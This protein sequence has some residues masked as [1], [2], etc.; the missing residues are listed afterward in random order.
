[1][2]VGVE[3]Y[4]NPPEAGPRY[5]D[6]RLAG[7]QRGPCFVWPQRV[8]QCPRGAL[9]G[10]YWQLAM[11]TLAGPTQTSSHSPVVKSAKSIAPMCF[12][13]VPPRDASAV[14]ESKPATR[15]SL[16]A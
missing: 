7:P 2:A 6:S 1:M 9:R 12:V 14:T 11:I 4:K 5:G 10:G 3:Q 15:W 16:A 13:S 8:P